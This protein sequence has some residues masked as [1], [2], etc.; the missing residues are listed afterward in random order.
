MSIA[1]RLQA[2]ER[3]QLPSGAGE[4]RAAQDDAVRTFLA[5]SPEGRREQLREAVAEARRTHAWPEGW[6]LGIPV[7]EVLL[8]DPELRHLAC[9]L[10][11]AVTAGE[12]A[13]GDA[14]ACP[15]P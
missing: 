14:A 10:L 11:A 8:A 5:L 1:A 4:D 2:V 15:V 3:R 9:E 6:P 13:P 12:E 7:R